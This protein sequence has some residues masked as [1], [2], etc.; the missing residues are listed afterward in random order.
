MR[1]VQF[2]KVWIFVCISI[3]LF[4]KENLFCHR[5]SL[6]HKRKLLFIRFMISAFGYPQRNF[7][8]G[9]EICCVTTLSSCENSLSKK[10][11]KSSCVNNTYL[12]TL[13]MIFLV[14]V[15][16][17]DGDVNSWIVSSYITQLS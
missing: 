14:L 1:H 6:M 3:I 13:H 17:M 10:N 9:K 5:L 11:K 12:A 8:Y 16:L 4:E 7:I 15:N 2:V